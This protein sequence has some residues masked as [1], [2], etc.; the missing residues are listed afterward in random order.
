MLFSPD[1]QESDEVDLT[2]EMKEQE[3]HQ[4]AQRRQFHGRVKLL[5]KAKEKIK[6]CQQKGGVLLVEGRAGVGKTAF[7]V[8]VYILFITYSK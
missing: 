5:S 1:S 7:M 2:A 3:V 4:D 8:T 6:E